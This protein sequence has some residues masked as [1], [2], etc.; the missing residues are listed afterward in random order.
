MS[1]VVIFDKKTQAQKVVRGPET[2]LD[3]A[4]VVVVGAGKS[5][6]KQMIRN[7]Q[8]LTI[9]FFDKQKLVIK[10]FFDKHEGK[11][12]SLVFNDDGQLVEAVIEEPTLAGD[13]LAVHYVPFQE[14]TQDSLGAGSLLET[15]TAS[16]KELSPLAK[17]AV[18][19]G[20]ALGVLAL[21]QKGGKGGGGHR[22][23]HVTADTTAPES[24]EL[25]VST[26]ADG[27]MAVNGKAEPGSRVDFV[28]PDGSKVSVTTGSDGSFSFASKLPQPNGTYTATATDAAGNTSKPLIG[29]YTA[30][31]NAD[32]S[33]PDTPTELKVVTKPNG[34]VT[35]SGK[36]EPNSTVSVTTTDGKTHTLQADND[37]NFNLDV[38]EQQPNGTVTATAKDA[39]GNVSPPATFEYIANPNID[40]DPP[41]APTELKVV[42]KPNGGVTVSGK[43]EPN[44]TVSV[45][46][47]DGKTHTLQADNDGNFNLDVNEQQPNGTVTAT[48]KDAAG[49]VS[50]PATF[51]YIAN[52]NIDVDPPSAPTELK[53]VTKPNGGVTVSGK[54]EPNSTVSVTTSDGKTHTLQADNDGN[55]NLDV[56]EQQPN[57]TVTAT[58]K[59]AAGNVSPP[60]TFEYIANPN[61]DVDPPSAPTELKVVTKPNGGVTVSGK[62]E[63]NSTVSVTTSD[64]KTHTLQADNDGNFNLDV[65]EQQP[66]GTVTAT[67]KDAAGNVSPPATFEY[68]ANPNIDVDP[69]SAPTE[70]K[71]VTKPNGGVT[72]SGKAEPN[73]TVSV[74]TTDG[75]THTLQADNDG[76]FNLDVNEQQPNG[77]VTATAKDAAGNVSPPATFEYIANPN[78]DVDPPSAPTE[79]KVVTKP[80]GGVTVSGKAEPN[81]TVSVTTTDGKTHT[82]QAD[83]DGNFNLDVNE[84]QPN[85]TVTATAKDAAG[86]VSPPSTF[87]YIANPNI[88]VDPP[89][90]PTDVVVTTKPNGG[91]T[92]RGH[93]EKGSV[94]T[95]VAPDGK[96]YTTQTDDDGH[97]TFDINKAQPNGDVTAT[98]TN[99]LGRVSPPTTVAYKADSSVDT[100]PP[101]P[102]TDLLAVTKSNGGVTISGNAEENS[103]ITVTTADGRSY[104]TKADQDGHFSVDIDTPQK[105]GDISV[106]ASDAANNVSE[107]AT[108]AYIADPN[109]DKTPPDAPTDLVAVPKPN[110]GLTISGNAEKN[111]TVHIITPDGTAHATSAD[112]KGHFTLDL[113]NPQPSGNVIATAVD[114]AGNRSLPAQLTYTADGL[115]APTFEITT[116]QATG[117]ATVTGKSTPGLKV[118][119]LFPGNIVKLVPAD[120]TGNFTVSDKAP[121]GAV[122]FKAVTINDAGQESPETVKDY[123][124]PYTYYEVTV[125]SYTDTIGVDGQ[126]LEHNKYERHDLKVPT[127]DPSP[128]LNGK[129]QGAGSNNKIEVIDKANGA[130]IASGGING[131]GTWSIQLPHRVDGVYGYQVKI[132]NGE[133]VSKGASVDIQLT[134][135]TIAPDRP[136]LENIVTSDSVDVQSGKSSVDNTP[137]LKGHAEANAA[138]IIYQKNTDGR[139]IEITRVIANNKGEWTAKLPF[140]TNRLHEYFAKAQDAAS[141]LSAGSNVLE[142]RF[143]GPTDKPINIKDGGGVW[144]VDGAGNV[145]GSGFDSVVG[146]GYD[147]R[148]Y[149]A[150]LKG[151]ANISGERPPEY[152]IGNIDTGYHSA[153]VGDTNG[154]G[155]NDVASVYPS[156]NGTGSGDVRLYK[157]LKSAGVPAGQYLKM[158]N[159]PDILGKGSFVS[160]VGDL[161]G[162][163]LM[164]VLLGGQGAFGQTRTSSIVFGSPKGIDNDTVGDFQFG[165]STHGKSSYNSGYSG[166]QS[167]AAAGDFFG[168]GSRSIVTA[169]GITVG[170]SNRGSIAKTADFDWVTGKDA[171]EINQ[172]QSVAGIGDTNGD[173]YSDVVVNDGTNL[174]VVFGGSREEFR[175]YNGK[176]VLDDKWLK[177]NSRG[178]MIDA[179]KAPASQ[180]TKYGDVRAIGDVNGDGLMDYAYS[181]YG[182]TGTGAAN[183]AGSYGSYQN[184][185]IIYGKA[186]SENIDMAN[187]TAKQGI[188]VPRDQ[189]DG[190][191]LAGR[192]D[193]NGDGLPDVYVG[194]YQNEGKLFLGGASLG[195]EASIKVDAT[196]YAQGDSGSNFIQGSAGNDTIYGKGGADVIYAGA[197]DDLIVLNKDNLY[198]LSQGFQADAGTSGR[199]ARVDGGAGIDTL[200]FEKD[201][202][203]F[204]LTGISIPGLGTIKTGVG[205]SRISNIECFDL[206]GGTNMKL[207]VDL[208]HVMDMTSGVNMFNKSNFSSGLGEVVS[209]NQV[210]IKGT[211][212]NEVE[213]KGKNEW[214]IENPELVYSQGHAYHVYNTVGDHQGQLLIEQTVNVTWA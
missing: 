67:A 68:I 211:S 148:K 58:A 142:A 115:Q 55:F 94:V 65:N 114:A 27:T 151:S 42:T 35:V 24:P 84:Q 191:S 177:D 85:G 91:I 159:N 29:S 54:A 127:N 165:A 213:V 185:Y 28:F 198:Y 110:G 38:N 139:E 37:G 113:V 99:D 138:V 53:V 97:F 98:A 81:S 88:D 8:T 52:P 102:P 109:V 150:L 40:V 41:S 166:S 144:S 212:D 31:P 143:N 124:N 135:D 204:D 21:T 190:A 200:G 149:N 77:T 13:P 172:V 205:L 137:T 194:S 111:S 12:N 79:L 10:K 168:D 203:E 164:D 70:L 105:N 34:G 175:R 178:Y 140:Q 126:K 30:D 95:L 63:P 1:D 117:E 66:N 15:V 202:T 11:E 201:V 60:A 171:L 199:L 5:A 186:D 48:A 61:I 157:G 152:Q 20:V 193:V 92:V 101:N 49:N 132:V 2:I 46:T 43:A 73:S 187:F 195:A 179:S 25:R 86:N 197:G 170:N 207:T 47:T 6:V 103:V 116:D 100:T 123:E 125:Q 189:A 181:T 59:D 107:P 130:L 89:S 56:N 133:R 156:T 176:I 128:T 180:P 87:E 210:L 206:T 196:G 18:L 19:G 173:G 75:K 9:E 93:A 118:R 36:A 74:T 154:D 44:S 33:P 3:T 208:N 169:R 45:T 174:Y 182:N 71:V 162:D 62:A 51:E 188:V 78:I 155:L 153:A 121:Q 134:I 106:T 160:G 57:G 76:N 122:Q 72:V 104:I 4:S 131:D 96:A 136:I 167:V 39:A 82:L 69:P 119:V 184:S 26:K 17:G 129:S 146:L 145:D 141:N 209:R 64:G 161:D 32:T 83:N 120:E 112:A 192:I 23:K 90:A 158:F 22:H 214:K 50:P 16:F 183:Q 7:G 163:G 14:G 80:N 108:V 147:N